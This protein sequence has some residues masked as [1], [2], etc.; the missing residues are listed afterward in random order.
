MTIADPAPWGNNRPTVPPGY[1]ITAIATDL[2]FRA[3]RSCFP[4]GDILVAEGAVAAA[5]RSC[6]EGFH[7]RDT[8]RRRARPR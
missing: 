2:G 6:A 4:N 8:S 5:S 3:R 7:R 1:T